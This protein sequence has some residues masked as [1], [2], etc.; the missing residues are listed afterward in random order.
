MAGQSA[1]RQTSKWLGFV[2]HGTLVLVDK[3]ASHFRDLF[4]FGDRLR[5]LAWSVLGK[6]GVFRGRLKDGTSIRMRSSDWETGNEVFL[7]EAYRTGVPASRVKRIVDVG[8]NIGYSCLYWAKQFP[9]A[10]IE[11][12]EPHPVHCRILCEHLKENHLTDRVRMY[13]AAAACCNA[14]GFLSD[15]G[16][17]SAVVGAPEGS[18]VPVTLVDF[19]DTMGL[20]PDPIDILKIDIEGGEYSLL[21]DQRFATLAQ[22]VGYLT[23]EYHER[24][25]DT[26]K[27]NGSWC[28]RRLR[29]L[30]FETEK[31]QTQ[32][33]LGMIRAWRT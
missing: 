26:A 21:S 6:P 13:P 7:V 3:T 18:A 22:R 11:T 15:K 4:G 23:M 33:D 5:Y 28:E 14:Q 20:D 29:D 31:Q 30:G 17:S 2:R 16:I 32:S 1:G 25:P 12:F 9:A 24:G 19:F 10:R 27:W 8:G